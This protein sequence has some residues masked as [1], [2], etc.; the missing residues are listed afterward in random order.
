MIRVLYVLNQ[1][2]VIEPLQRYHRLWHS[3]LHLLAPSK[4][5]PPPPPKEEKK[6]EKKEDAEAKPEEDH[7]C[8]MLCCKFKKP[9]LKKYM[10][11]L[12]LPDS[13][14]SYTGKLKAMQ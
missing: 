14:D 10:E 3:T 4:K 13:I 1:G 7:Y 12:Q 5:K 11:H 9:P 6:E 2:V 8:D